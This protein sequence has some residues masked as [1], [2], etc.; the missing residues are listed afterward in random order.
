LTAIG[1]ASAEFVRSGQSLLGYLSL[2]F[3]PPGVGVMQHTGLLRTHWLAL[4]IAVIASTALAMASGALVMQSINRLRRPGRPGVI[5]PASI[6]G[7][8]R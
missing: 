6:V 2:F 3:V 1:G 4:L 8:H 5:S 7:E